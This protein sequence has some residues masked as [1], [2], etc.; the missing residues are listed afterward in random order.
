MSLADEGPGEGGNAPPPPPA[1]PH[2]DPSYLPPYFKG[3]ADEDFNQ[4]CRKLE[5]A[6]QNYPVGAP[7]LAH[8]LPSKLDGKAFAFWDSLPAQTRENFQEAKNAL[9]RVFGRTNQ[10]R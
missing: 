7:S 5:I 4:W 8:A 1:G 3:N 2:W 9:A 6:I 10:L